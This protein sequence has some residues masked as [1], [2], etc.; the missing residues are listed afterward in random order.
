METCGNLYIVPCT[1]HTIRMY[2][3]S[4]VFPKNIGARVKIDSE[5]IST[6]ETAKLIA[7]QVAL[8]ILSL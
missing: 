7:Q 3:M 5:N 8:S 1:P 4:V 6:V 2:F